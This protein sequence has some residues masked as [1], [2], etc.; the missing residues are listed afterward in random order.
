MTIEQG[1]NQP[2]YGACGGP[3][4]YIFVPTSLGIIEKV[5][6]SVTKEELNLTEFDLW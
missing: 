4:E 1:L 3:L 6:H 5:R 2:Y